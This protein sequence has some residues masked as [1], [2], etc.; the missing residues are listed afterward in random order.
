MRMAKVTINPNVCKSC[1]LCITACPKQI[2]ALDKDT[3]NAKGYHPATVVE[4][5]K[6]IGCSACAIMC[7][8]CAITVER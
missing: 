6:C 7:P 3:M 8:D 1:E 2:I 5:E 4:P